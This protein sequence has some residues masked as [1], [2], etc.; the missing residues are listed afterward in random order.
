MLFL[1]KFQQ[2]ILI[3]IDKIILKL[4]WKGKRSRYSVR[5]NSTWFSSLSYSYYNQDYVILAG[6]E[7]YRAVEEKKRTQKQICTKYTQL[8]FSTKL[9]KY[10]SKGKITFSTDDVGTIRHSQAKR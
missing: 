2:A 3:D 9:Q 7:I 4:I 10:L 1:P 8:I 5:N 6:E